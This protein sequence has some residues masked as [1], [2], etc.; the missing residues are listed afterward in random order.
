MQIVS[1]PK[2]HH[3]PDLGRG[4]S[5][6]PLLEII[7]ADAYVRAQPSICHYS[8]VIMGGVASQTTSLAIVYST[9]YTGMDQRKYKS[10]ASLTFVQGIHRSPVNFPHKGQWRENI[11]IWWRHY[12]H[13]VPCMYDKLTT[14]RCPLAVHCSKEFELSSS[15]LRP[16]GIA[17]RFHRF[18]YYNRFHKLM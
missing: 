12:V 3:K 4:T 13:W 1:H 15:S 5:N 7:M 8:A 9:V 6:K 18:H 2:A 14:I 17:H 11:C 16:C 10:S